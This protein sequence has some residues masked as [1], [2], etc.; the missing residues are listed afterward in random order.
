[1]GLE[2]A[3]PPDA[4]RQD[5]VF[6][7]SGG[8]QPGRDGSRVPMPWL[9]GRPNAGFSTAPTWLPEPAGWDRFAVDAQLASSSSPLTHYMRWLA[10][11]RRLT[12]RLPDRLE[13]GAAPA[14]VLLYRRGPLVAA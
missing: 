6:S 9:R 13:W 1:L 3:D 8:R 11:R 10:M 12:G 2:Q 14:G 7:H 5:P 4:E